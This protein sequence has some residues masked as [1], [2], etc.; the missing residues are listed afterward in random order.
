MFNTI[1][2]IDLEA[3]KKSLEQQINQLTLTLKELTADNVN[4]LAKA[5][6]ELA[7]VKQDIADLK[8]KK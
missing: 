5:H 1:K 6:W 7:N 3:K 8:K 2:L 4:K